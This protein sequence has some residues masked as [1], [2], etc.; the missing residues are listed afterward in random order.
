M[1]GRLEKD[2][3]SG[4]LSKRRMRHQFGPLSIAD[5]TL[6]QPLTKRPF[7]VD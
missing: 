6:A 1:I 4:R 5:V 7:M 2:L 3:G